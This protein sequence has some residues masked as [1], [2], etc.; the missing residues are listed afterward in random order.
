MEGT[1]SA[2]LAADPVERVRALAPQIAAASE[3][4][5]RQ[6]RLPDGL[7]TALHGAGLFRL[8]L[9][10]PFGGEEIDPVTFIR[11]IEEV[12]KHDAST[13][14]CL[15]Q[16]C[17]TAMAASF[18][19]PEVVHEIWDDPR[20]VLAWGPGPGARAVAIEGGYRVTGNWSFASGGRHATWFGAFCAIYEPDGTPRRDAKGAPLTRTMLFPASAAPMT[21]IWNVIGLRGTGSDAY[22]VSDFFVPEKHSFQRDDM[23]ERRYHAPLYLFPTNSIFP[24]AFSCVA[25][26]IARATLDAFMVLACEKTPRGYKR[27]MAEN[28]VIQS[29]VAQAEARLRAARRYIIGTFE[30]IWEAVQ[31]TGVLKIEQRVAIRLAA[32]H[33]IHQA[34]DVVDVAYDLTG[35][36]AIFASNPFERRFRDM[37]TVAQQLQG[38]QSHFETVGRYM[39]GQEPDLLFL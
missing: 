32:T 19:A 38:R 28:A 2:K 3:E 23:S 20:A 27:P 7:M 5:D 22:A 15:G 37:H 4:G 34:K 26:G 29:Q 14:W 13:A 21:D 12:A 10:R 6:R 30:E 11:V 31:A 24:G 25:L 36:T 18:L 17:V 16:N 35:A 39:F 33:V 1:A 9:A 8:L